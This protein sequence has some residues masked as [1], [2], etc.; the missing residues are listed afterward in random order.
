VPEQAF[1]LFHEVMHCVFGDPTLMHNWFKKGSI[2]IGN[3]DW[4]FEPDALNIAMDFVINAQLI[5]GK[6]G[7]YN[8]DWLYEPKYSKEGMEAAVDVYQ[9]VLRDRKVSEQQTH[10]FDMVL[11]PGWKDG[12]PPD[13]VKRDPD[14]WAGV[15]ASAALAADMQGKLP[16]NLKRLIGEILDPKVSWQDHLRTTMMRVNGDDALDWT[17]AD[18]RMLVRDQ[19]G[20]EPIFFG[21]PTGFGAGTVVIAVDT[22]GSIGPVQLDQFFGEMRGIIQDI[23]PREVVIIECDAEVGDV[24]FLEEIDQLEE[25]RAKE[26]SGGGGTAF[27]PVFEEINKRGLQPDMLVYLTDLYGSF[28]K[29][30]PD[31]PTI[32]GC[33]SNVKKAPFGEVVSID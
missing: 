28:P 24:F 2:F 16:G 15:I 8:K 30:E 7:H 21:R 14:Q 23:N 1:I 3:N 18:R 19:F 20:F 13:Q 11:P 33:I 27:A 10:T 6:C 25:W 4:P 22:S 12:R 17:Q 9:L 26:L 32:W 5:A 31:Y 29:E